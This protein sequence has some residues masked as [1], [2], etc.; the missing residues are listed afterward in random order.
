MKEFDIYVPCRKNDGT[1]VELADIES[2]KST[3]IK[4][5]GGFTHLQQRNKG[6]WKVGGTTFHDDV[7]ILRVLDDGSAAFDMRKFK[8][9]L[10][11][12]LKQD[13]VLIVEREVRCV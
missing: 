9:T 12:T 2:I 1:L 6:A 13:S 3:L 8:E 10:E 5:F 4:T 7:T 11:R